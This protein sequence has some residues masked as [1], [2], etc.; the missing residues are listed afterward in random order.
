MSPAATQD[1]AKVGQLL[2]DPKAPLKARFRALFTLK[3]LGGPE[4]LE[5]MFQAFSDESA[6]LKH[7][8]AYCL[9]QMGDKTAV[10][11]LSEV[12]ADASREAIVRHEAGEAL[13]A[14]GDLSVLPLLRKH[15]QDPV[16]EV[17]DTCDLAIKRLEYIQSG[18]ADEEKDKL[19]KNPYESV[20][21]APPL[22]EKDVGKLEAILLDE[23]LPLFERYRAMFS[24]R[25]L[26]T[27]DS[28]LA[29]AKGKKE[30]RNISF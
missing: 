25:N 30:K 3:N 12:L 27:D 24:L 10:P 1:L 28:I 14:I 26:G 20:D 17:A 5:F 2:N 29:I 4:A 19:T 9:G 11:K 13:G 8:V 6:L 18:K 7:E 23:S 16:K 22:E 21:P 15:A